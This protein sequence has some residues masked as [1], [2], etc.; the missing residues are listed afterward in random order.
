MLFP[1]FIHE[2]DKYLPSC[3]SVPGKS[4]FCESNMTVP[5]ALVTW[6]DGTAAFR[7]S[8]RLYHL[9]IKAMKELLNT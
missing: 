7:M 5:V 8:L 3:Y 1:W 4:L 9:E 6:E 2:F